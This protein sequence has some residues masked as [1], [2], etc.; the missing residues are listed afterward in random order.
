MSREDFKKLLD[1]IGCPYREE[2]EWL[3]VGKR[4]RVSPPNIRLNHRYI[5]SLPPNTKFENVGDVQLDHNSLVSLPENL[6]FENGGHV[7]LDYNNLTSLSEG[8][9]FENGGHVWLDCNSIT[10]LPDNLKFENGGDVW[11]EHNSLT[12]LPNNLKFENGG[13]V[14]LNNN[15]L[16]ALPTNIKFRNRGSIYLGGNTTNIFRYQDKV[17]EV[18]DETTT[19]TL[20]SKI[21][22]GLTIKKTCRFCGDNFKGMHEIIYRA[23]KDDLSAH[24][25][26]VKEAVEDL[27]FKG[28]RR[29]LPAIVEDIKARGYVTVQDYRLLTG[30]CR[31]GIRM[32]LE[33][34]GV[35]EDRMSIVVA[36][37]LTK[38]SYG[39]ED[40]KEALADYNDEESKVSSNN[41]N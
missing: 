37:E 34:K 7:W 24:G 11:L 35:K 18:I 41:I 19:L 36:L 40:F 31:E 3:V 32:F 9:K 39:H 38:G 10:S 13:S 20:S 8:I 21:M 23:Q 17:V 12:S 22:K 15:N 29:D 25:A 2:D 1:K 27:E 4:D 30:A 33:E 14:K 16:T 5:T 6:R 26:S 28:L